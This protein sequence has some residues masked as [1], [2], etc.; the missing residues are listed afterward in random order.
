M[1]DFVKPAGRTPENTLCA[2]A[3]RWR[4]HPRIEVFDRAA[5]SLAKR[6]N[7]ITDRLGFS[8]GPRSR[9]RG[10]GKQSI[11]FFLSLRS[12]LVDA[13]G[14]VYSADN[15]V[16]RVKPNGVIEESKFIMPIAY[17]RPRQAFTLQVSP[18]TQPGTFILRIQGML[19]SIRSVDGH[20]RSKPLLLVS[21]SWVLPGR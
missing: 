2:C 18:S 14:N 19:A 8:V 5:R 17:L 6:A 9:V 4:C 7:M 16:L 11:D 10:I 13:A 12:L 15:S 3:M 20:T 1:R 21:A